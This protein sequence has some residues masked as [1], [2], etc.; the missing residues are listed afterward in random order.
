MT[1]ESR[2]TV[3][4][5]VATVAASTAGLAGPTSAAIDN[6][7]TLVSVAVDGTQ[8]DA[9]SGFQAVSADGRY[10]AFGSQATN[11][12]PNVDVDH[13]QNIYLR[14]NDTGEITLINHNPN[15]SANGRAVPVPTI[16]GDGRYVV[17]P[18]RV[19]LNS[20]AMRLVLWD[21]DTDTTTRISRTPVG[22]EI[23]APFIRS[24][25]STDGSAVV[26]QVQLARRG[27]ND[28]RTRLYHYEVPTGTTTQLGGDLAYHPFENGGRPAISGNGR[29]VAY[30]KMGTENAAGERRSELIRVDT[31]SGQQVVVRRTEPMEFLGI[32]SPS[33]DS[34]GRHL[35]FSQTQPGPIPPGQ[36]VFSVISMYDA[37]TDTVQQISRAVGVGNPNGSSYEP[38]V[39]G[40]GRYVVFHSTA[41]NLIDEPTV[42]VGSYGVYV[43][44]TETGTTERI[45]RNRQG[46][47]P[48]GD[49][50]APV[51]SEDG[52]AVTFMSDAR[53]LTPGN[54]AVLR[55]YLWTR[56]TT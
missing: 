27:A 5:I 41:R 40:T 6:N 20:V 37:N 36:D 22:E 46:V 10:V 44:D 33:L 12:G 25:I 30:V 51:I 19:S 55:V 54:S 35:A 32:R 23:K 2:W 29:F 56:P 38:D 52:T 4:T 14:D 43:F 42:K 8:P 48:R 7:I 1:R 28:Q 16:S 15:G 50:T 26:Y 17:Y 24:A 21:R 18:Q 34:A 45:D 13:N 3:L 53:N 47:Y 31:E 39:S 49:G 9:Q 11:L